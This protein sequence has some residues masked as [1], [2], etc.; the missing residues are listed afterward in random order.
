[1]RNVRV[2]AEPEPAYYVPRAQRSTELICLVVRTADG[3][4]DLSP[5][6]RSVVASIDPMQPV[7]N[8]TTLDRIVSDSI[9]DRRFYAIATVAFALVTLLLAAAGLYGVT[10]YSITARTREIGVRVALGAAPVRVVRMLIAQGVRPVLLGLGIGLIGAAWLGRLIE[11]FLFE[12]QTFDP[13]TYVA[14][15]CWVL[16]LTLIACLLPAI[17]AGRVSPILALRQE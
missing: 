7:V 1:V 11:R 3:T 10:S 8:A 15:A 5:A 2:D 6:V 14:A 17:R 9:A 12:V 16:T 4:P 13:L